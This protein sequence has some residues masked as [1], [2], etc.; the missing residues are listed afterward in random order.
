MGVSAQRVAGEVLEVIPLVTR[1]VA[2][3]IRKSDRSMKLAHVGLL[4]MVARS[5]RSLSELSDFHAASMP[6]MSKTITTIEN[7]GWVVRIRSDVD[8]RVVM[9]QVTPAG[10][11]ALREVYNRAITPISEALDSLTVAQ[12]QKLSDGLK[13]L[14]DT[15]ADPSAEPGGENRQCGSST[16]GKR[17][18]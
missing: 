11:A 12:R 15:L 8:R 9:V 18:A 13:I 1:R 4:G 16:N 14:R 17:S 7:L 2:A 6:T 3:N 10:K 5:P